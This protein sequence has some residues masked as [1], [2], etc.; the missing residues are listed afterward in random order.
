MMRFYTGMLSTDGYGTVGLIIDACVIIMTIVTLSVN[1]SLIRFGLDSKYDKAQVFSIGL[2]TVIAGLALF[3]FAA[4]LLGNIGTFKGYTVWIYFYVFSGSVKSC[5]ALFARSAGYVK[6][7]AVDGIFTTLTNIILNLIF[8]LGLGLGVKGYLLS[9]ILADVASTVFV[10]YLANLKSYIQLFGLNPHLRRSM[11]RYCIPMIPTTIMWW[12]IGV[13]D[14]FFIEHFMEIGATG[15]Y[16]A[17]SR[18]PNIIIMLSVIFSQAWNMS[19]ITEKNSRTIARFYTNVF[20]IF[21]SAIYIMAAGLLLV[22]RPALAIMTTN[23]FDEA[24][25]FSAFLILAVIFN[26]F[27][28]FTGSVYVASKKSMRSMVTSTLGAV[29][30]TLLNIVFI[31]LWGLHGAAFTTLVSYVIIFAVRAV[32]T[33]KIVLMDLKLAKMFSNLVIITIMSVIVMFTQNTGLYYA[34]LSGFFLLALVI[35]FR[36]AIAAIQMIRR[37]S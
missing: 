22:I 8:M 1:D 2:T 9:V 36:S 18:F 37:K 33:R 23:G 11:F 16:K 17:A 10:F 34:G 13:A 30:N 14:G 29:I 15:V 6:L 5:C 7:Y 25:K 28:T 26:C 24:Y 20:N 31:P 19:A 3:A 12:I 32:D 27:S 21:Q 35:N 4:P